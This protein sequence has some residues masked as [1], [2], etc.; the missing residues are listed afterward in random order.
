[1]AHLHADRWK[2][3]EHDFEL[4]RIFA[5]ALE[6]IKSTELRTDGVSRA[7]YFAHHGLLCLH[8]ATRDP[9]AQEEFQQRKAGTFKGAGAQPSTAP[10]DAQLRQMAAQIAELQRQLAERA[11]PAPPPKPPEGGGGTKPPEGGGT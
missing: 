10:Q 2:E 5:A 11:P 4:A 3:L 9:A 8:P 6:L 7:E 1:M